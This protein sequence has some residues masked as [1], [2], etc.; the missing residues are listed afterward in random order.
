MRPRP[1]F[2]LVVSCEHASRARPP[3]F[4]T[5]GIDDAT[6]DTHAAWDPGARP[7]A[8]RVAQ[9]FGAPA[10]Y[11][12]WTRLYCDLNRSPGTPDVVPSVAFGVEIPS[13]ARLDDAA[14]AARVRAHHQ[15]YWDTVRGF[16]RE[17][18]ERADAVL[19]FSVHSFVE[20]YQ[21]RHRAVDLGILIDP[22]AP[23][24]AEVSRHFAAQVPGTFLVRENEPYDGRADA[25]TTALRHELGSA[26]YAGVE[27]E[28]NQRHLGRLDVVGDAV[29]A[30]LAG[31]LTMN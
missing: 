28:L 18:L 10:V 5:A 2:A 29:V 3:D 9:R 25:L 11:G 24:E 17:G 8:E 23:L 30:A 26:R 1:R 21:G 6:F 19:H 31:L 4:D 14:R 20:E 15:P 12:Q 16:V 27:L 7:I 13:N 22:A